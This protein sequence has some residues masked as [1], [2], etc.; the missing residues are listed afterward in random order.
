MSVSRRAVTSFG[1]FLSFALTATA[2]GPAE[3]TERHAYTTEQW[4]EDL[5]FLARE[6][7]KRHRNAF[8][9]ISPATFD[10]EVAALDARIP[11]LTDH[12]IVVGLASIVALVGDGHTRLALPQDP[13]A[14]FD[15]AHTVTDPPKDSSLFMHHLPVKVALFDDGLFVR[16]ATAEYRDLI[17]A[18]V[19]R[20]GSLRAD[21]AIEA[22][23]PVVNYDNEPG[24]DFIAPTLLPVPEVLH[25]TRVS[26]TPNEVTLVVEKNGQTKNVTLKPLALFGKPRFIEAREQLANV[27]LWEKDTEKYYWLTNIP[28]SRALYVQVNRIGSAREENINDFARRIR[29]TF[30]KTGAQRVVVDL[31]HNPGGDGNM[32]R[33]LF[34]AL[35][36]D[37]AI[38]SLGHLFV[39]IGRE[40]FSAAQMLVN[41]FEHSSNAL[42][43]GEPTGGSPSSY[44]DSRKFKL[45]NSGLTVRAST[46]YWRDMDGNEKRE[47]T[48]PYI[49][50]KLTAKD[51][52]AGNDPVMNAVTSFDPSITPEKLVATVQE[53][54][55][56]PEAMHICWA[57]AADPLVERP[58]RT[59]GMAA[60]GTLLQQKG[61]AKVA[62]DWFR[63]MI[64]YLPDEPAAY[65]GLA[66]ALAATGQAD[67]AAEA[68]T[69]ARDLS[70]QR[71]SSAGSSRSSGS[72]LSD[73]PCALQRGLSGFSQLPRPATRHPCSSPSG[74][75]DRR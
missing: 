68:R 60:C 12:E 20:V 27:P 36:R 19:V 13:D 71:K 4:R 39:L 1:L 2:Q 59:R 67:D 66:A 31:R 37:S 28:A 56:W 3:K 61:E 41:D 47:A 26:D 8:H 51:Y 73:P 75:S 14:G 25:A 45:P 21:S 52:F 24:F 44:G 74:L 50:V 40:T 72:P 32:D 38:N 65:A 33:P 63:A 62:V 18:R 6:L 35:V 42:F 16:A 15:R 10:S 46:I 9:K 64:N 54:A 7:P 29:E 49:P 69:K 30:R 22:L 70:R 23:R 48:N 11:S 43:V 17:G 34:T 53:K 5:Q 58:L 57:Y 55:G